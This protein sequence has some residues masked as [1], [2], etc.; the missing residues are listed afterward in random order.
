MKFLKT[1]S[2]IALSIFVVSCG[3][4]TKPAEPQEEVVEAPVP[5]EYK[6]EN[7]GI[8]LKY[9][10]QLLVLAEEDSTQVTFKGIGGEAKL[11]IYKDVRKD[12]DGN[13]LSINAYFDQDKVVKPGHRHAVSTF[14]S[15][16]YLISGRVGDELY[17]QKSYFK[18]GGVMTAILS[19]PDAEK[20]TWNSHYL[21][22]FGSIQ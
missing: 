12:K 19:Y 10:P 1:F 16:H 3:G 20:E 11:H 14:K 15:D 17:Y 13:V 18:R 4:N 5:G 6:N 22:L 2:L 7:L 9:D 21:E 8:N